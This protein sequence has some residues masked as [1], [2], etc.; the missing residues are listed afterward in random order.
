MPTNPCN[1]KLKKKKLM[2]IGFISMRDTSTW[3]AL[4]IFDIPLERPARCPCSAHWQSPASLARG[5]FI[6]HFSTINTVAGVS[7]WA[8][9]A[10]APHFP[11]SLCPS[12]QSPQKPCTSSISLHISLTDPLFVFY[13]VC[14]SPAE[15]RNA[16]PPWFVGRR[17]ADS[18]GREGRRSE[19]EGREVPCTAD[20]V[21]RKLYCSLG[22]VLPMEYE[23]FLRG[24]WQNLYHVRRN[25]LSKTNRTRS[26]PNL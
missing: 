4:A 10:V 6:P 3:S 26:R 12:I 15:P 16:E 25:K 1:V 18:E 13:N 17:V 14:A 21:S 5:S 24:S 23:E 11:L 20:I 2:K 19:E 8:V 22:R 9:S 7:Q